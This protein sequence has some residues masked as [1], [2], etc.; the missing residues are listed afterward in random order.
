MAAGIVAGPMVGQLEAL[1]VLT[2]GPPSDYLALLYAT[3]LYAICG[4]ALGL[5]VGALLLLLGALST[6]PRRLSTTYTISF[7]LVASCM[8]IAL[9][10]YEVNRLYFKGLGLPGGAEAMILAG[11]A[12]LFLAGLWIGPILLTRTPFKIVIRLRGTAALYGALL[13]LAVVFSLSP[14]SGGHADGWI[15]P[16]RPTPLHLLDRPNVLVIV[17]DSLRADHVGSYT[18]EAQATPAL[19][20]LAA[21]GVLFEQA[22]ASSSDMRASFASLLTSQTPSA[23]GVIDHRT[24]LAA[25]STTLSEVL[26]EEGM[27][28]GA[29]PNHDH[30]ARGAGLQ[31]GFDWYSLMSPRYPLLASQSASKLA[32]FKALRGLARSQLLYEPRVDEHY[33]PAAAV[34][35]RATDFIGMNRDRRWFLV[36]HLMELHAP[37]FD[38]GEDS[39]ELAW[40]GLPPTEEQQGLRIQQAYTQELL[41]LDQQLGE[42]MAW[43]DE[44]GL[45]DGT[46]V[47]LTAERG[48]EL[49]ER[50]GWGAGSGLHDELIRVPLILRL[51]RCELAGTVVPWQVRLLDVPTTIAHELGASLPDAWQGQDLL[52][53]PLW[54]LGAGVDPHPLHDPLAGERSWMELDRAA[55]S[56][57]MHG[58]DPQRSLRYGGFKLLRH[59]AEN[60]HDPGLFELFDLVED[61][62]ETLDLSPVRADLAVEM[63]RRLVALVEFSRMVGEGGGGRF[64]AASED[65]ARDMGYERPEPERREPSPSEAPG[66]GT[67]PP[68]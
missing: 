42:F 59:G 50:G 2:S 68:P 56:E 25:E 38:Y 45:A 27:I 66:A 39:P 64:D 19:D 13:L 54:T 36:L 57:A 62:G 34:F 6:Q 9:T 48:T 67:S 12:L 49:G 44:Q 20:E 23:H 35:E 29:L 4:G 52:D 47:V 28:T 58:A 60:L 22:V 61:P 1:Y 18:P 63:E 14:V 16:D 51:P 65:R 41:M 53:E 33:Q 43:L 37:L 26:W 32:G 7:L 24:V 40:D 17:V 5:V 30:L 31:Q 15:A 3:V 21:E 8:G 55:L 46:L 10:R 11:F